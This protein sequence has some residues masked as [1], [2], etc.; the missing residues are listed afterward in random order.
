MLDALKLNPASG[1][2]WSRWAGEPVSL[3]EPES[4]LRA[5]KYFPSFRLRPVKQ[6]KET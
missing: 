4:I 3:A 5:A 1:K 2:L 6:P